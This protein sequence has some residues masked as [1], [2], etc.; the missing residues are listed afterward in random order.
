M[1]S[2]PPKLFTNKPKKALLRNLPQQSLTMETPSLPNTPPPPPPP[3]P[4]TDSFARRYRFLWPLL[5]TVNIGVGAYWFM[6]TKRD[7]SVEKAVKVEEIP[8]HTPTPASATVA[9]TEPITLKPVIVETP[10]KPLEPVPENQQR[11]LFK[12]LLEEKRKIKPKNAE[13]KKQLD[14]EKAILKQ[15]IRMKSIQNI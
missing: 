9:V 11:E 5:L 7:T 2:D 14:E 8:T 4:S 13:E 15:F 6:R 12:W 1:S 3:K 10:P